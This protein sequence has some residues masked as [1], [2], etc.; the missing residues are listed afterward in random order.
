VCDIEEDINEDGKCNSRDCPDEP[1]IT[2]VE[3][4]RIIRGNV[5]GDGSISDGEGFTVNHVSGTG[6]YDINFDVPFPTLPSPV[7]TPHALTYPL[8]AT[9]RSLGPSGF[10]ARIIHFVTQDDSESGFSFI[11][12]GPR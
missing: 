9:I 1:P 11:V 5:N 7:V 8:T 12:M 3:P 4:L 2:P 10:T 6:K